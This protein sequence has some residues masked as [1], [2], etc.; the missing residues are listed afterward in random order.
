MILFFVTLFVIGLKK[1][2]KKYYY[3]AFAILALSTYSY[4]TS[5]FFVPIF[6]AALLVYIVATKRIDWKELIGP[7]IMLVILVLLDSNIVIE[8]QIK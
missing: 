4:G 6:L 8:K 7:S 5:Y 3:G 2:N 1:K